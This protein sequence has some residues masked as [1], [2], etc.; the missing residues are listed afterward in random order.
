M[1]A[2]WVNE[3]KKQQR[4]IEQSEMR[5][6]G[7]SRFER[8]EIAI[9]NNPVPV[10][11]RRAYSHLQGERLDGEATSTLASE[12]AIGSWPASSSLINWQH[13]PHF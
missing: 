1:I 3:N 6:L 7:V 10:G 8:K 12:G 11:S 4:V 9:I 13:S 5:G 2:T